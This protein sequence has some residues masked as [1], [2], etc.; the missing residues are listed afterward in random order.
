MIERSCIAP[1]KLQLKIGAQVMLLRNM[2]GTLV[3]GSLGLVTGFDGESE[4]PIVRFVYGREMTISYEEW[5]IKLP[6][7]FQLYTS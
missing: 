7:K 6:S 1:K 4:H 2:D 3:N 5:T